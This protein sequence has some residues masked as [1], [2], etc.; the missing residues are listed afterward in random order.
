MKKRL[1]RWTVPVLLLAAGLCLAGC[2]GKKETDPEAE[3]VLKLTITPM[4]TPTPE[5]SQINPDAVTT[6]GGLT[7]VNSYLEDKEPAGET[8]E[9]SADSGEDTSQEET[10]EE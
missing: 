8:E 2:G 4:A 10:G 5:P 1:R 9:D 6:S 7:M 3:Q